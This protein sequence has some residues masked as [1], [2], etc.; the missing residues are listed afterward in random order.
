M[1]SYVVYNPSCHL[2]KIR[3]C[4]Q[5]PLNPPRKRGGGLWLTPSPFTGRVGER[6]QLG[7]YKFLSNL[8]CCVSMCL[9]IPMRIIAIDGFTAR[10]E[11]KGVFR[12]VSLFMMQDEV[13]QIDDFVMVHVGYAIQKV[14]ATEAR[15]TWELLDKIFEETTD[16]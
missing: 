11:A 12:D 3:Y 13:L 8:D 1:N 2:F 7:L 16:A 9:A 6:W 15:T 10:C 14:E 5:S 4:I